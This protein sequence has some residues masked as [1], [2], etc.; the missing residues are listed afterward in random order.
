MQFQDR[1]DLTNCDREP[2]HIPGSIQPHGCML[3]CDPHFEQVLRSSANAG[4]MLGLG[5]A[6][7]AGRP[8][9][10]LLGPQLLHAVV[11]ASARSSEPRRPGLLL[12]HRLSP[13]GDA[14]DIAVHRHGGRAFV[15]FEPAASGRDA[16]GPMEIARALIARV[17]SASSLDALMAQAPRYLR[18]MLGYD[19][20]MVYRFAEDGSGKVVGEARR[21]DL[22]P[23]LGTH[24]PAADIPQQARALYVLNTIRVIADSSGPRAPLQPEAKEWTDPSDLSH[25]HL[26]SVSPIHLEYLRNMG[27]AAS[28][29]VSILVG[30]ALW[31]LIACHHY[32]PRVLGMAQR[33]AAEL[34]GDFV[35]LQIEATLHRAKLEAAVHARNGLDAL[36]RDLSVQENAIDHLVGRISDFSRLVPADGVGLWVDGRWIADGSVPPRGAVPA[37]IGFLGQQAQ[38]AVWSSHHLAGAFPPAAAYAAQAAGVLCVPIS[39]V[40][41]DYLLF[42]RKEQVQTVEWAGNP[43]KVYE[44]G[45]HGDRLTPRR[46]FA[47]WKQTVA[48]RCLPWSDADRDIAQAMRSALAEIILR[49]NELLSAER[50]KADIR[51]KVLHEELNHRVK[52]ILA[53][54]KALLSQPIEPGRTLEDYAT[55]LRGRIMALAYAHDQ[56]IRSD[57]GGALR[58]LLEAELS[59]YRA[60]PGAVTLVGPAVGLDAR[61]F[62]VMALVLHELSTNAAKYGALS[63]PSGRLDVSW[64]VLPNG[65]CAVS[66][67]EQGGPPVRPPARQ[68]FGSVL[69]N[70]SIPFDL[71]GISEL[72]Y[73]P[74]GLRARLMVPARFISDRPTEPVREPA[75][76]A[77]PGLPAAMLAGKRL[78]LVEDQLVIAIDVER[79]LAAQGAAAIDTAATVA[80]ALRLLSASPPDLAVLDVNLGSGNS[81]P[82]ADALVAR[83][84]PFVFA[85]GYGDS[86]MIPP[87]LK[88]VPVVRKP[89]SEQG[90]VA[91]LSRLGAAREG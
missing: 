56:V 71:G 36:M 16:E 25:A 7:L 23:F 47:I 9:R 64:R 66:W 19:R 65:D 14:F 43:E 4:A 68:G 52:N 27:V 42:F 5:K 12:A 81:L 49:N 11:N 79:M 38:L 57:G 13:D 17:Q 50:R 70:R 84:V 48:E 26:R 88:S 78:Q 2:I 22:E 54:I 29:S 61:A 73:D 87:A 35:S 24:F 91:A 6:P 82:V 15:E 85:T 80:E 62:S 20:V 51:Q 77:A 55:S 41:R 45:P 58:D 86:I 18:G 46:S 69:L 37:L 40:S 30:G 3:A 53:L 21:G 28:M 83:G 75:A 31:G 44:T 74:L 90:L 8:M 10:D 39:Q 72:E 59:P 89:Y 1:V 60:M 32:A 34:L 63:A 67:H 76:P 33:V